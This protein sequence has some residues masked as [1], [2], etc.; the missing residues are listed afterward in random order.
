M[1]LAGPGG[2]AARAVFPSTPT[3]F[4]LMAA[5]VNATQITMNP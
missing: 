2:A 3:P 4:D 5:M 1:R